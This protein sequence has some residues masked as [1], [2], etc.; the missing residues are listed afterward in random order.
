MGS[1]VAACMGPVSDVTTRSGR[2][3]SN[4]VTCVVVGG[5]SDAPPPGLLRTSTS[6]SGPSSSVSL[7]ACTLIGSVVIPGRNVSV[8][9][10]GVSVKSDVSTAVLA[11]LTW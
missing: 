3:L 9:W 4:R 5:P 11:P 6:D 2:S 10:P 1:P 7:I 8:P